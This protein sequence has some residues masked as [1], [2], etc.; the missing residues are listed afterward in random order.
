MNVTYFEKERIFKL[1]T[2]NTSYLLGI[3]DEENFI[4]HIYYGK[5][6]QGHNIAYRMRTQ[7]APFVPSRNNRER[8]SF[9]DCFPFEYPTTG[10]GDYRESCLSI[11]TIGG[12][13]GCNLSYVSHR[14]L[15]GKPQLEGLPATFADKE[16]A[17]TLEL[18]CVDN[19]IGMK[20]LLYYTAFCDTD[21][22]TRSVKIIN[23]GTQAF[24]LTKVLSACLD[25]D[26]QDYEMISLHGSWA[27]E[28]HIQRKKVGYG[29]QKVSSFRGESS[30]QDHPFLALVS[31]N[32]TQAVSYTHL[33]VYKRQR[34]Y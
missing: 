11:R 8:C 4:G 16:T 26:N 25:M 30:H 6:L 33:D 5:R 2:P 3:V 15:E 18:T 27:R 28:R 31:P 23:E 20:V 29:I 19:H 10:L 34:Q 32:T 17:T 9:Y 7:E 14:I 21:V 13:S 24:Y 22:I 1:D 12:Y